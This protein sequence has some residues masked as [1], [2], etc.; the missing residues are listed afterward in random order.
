M[1]KAYW[2]VVALVVV[3]L[4]GVAALSFYPGDFAV[5]GIKLNRSTLAET[6]RGVMHPD[7]TAQSDTTVLAGPHQHPKG[8]RAPMDTTSKTI[9][10]IGDSMLEGLGPRLAAYADQNGHKLINVIW[11]SSS[12]E[13]WGS[14]GRLRTLIEEYKPNYIFVCLG[15]NELFVKDIRQKRQRYLDEMLAEIGNIPYVWIG[16]PNWKP[17][18]GIND[19]LQA[20]IADGCFYL[21]N[22]QHF[23]RA[24]DGAHPT[25]ASAAAWCDRVCQ[26]VMNTSTYPIMLNVP[27]VFKSRAKTIVYQPVQ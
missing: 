26:W 12:T 10:F 17:D 5:A 27:S 16:P 1:N 6:L 3:A 2:G 19:M 22:G 9:L 25:K 13:I 4:A 14:T 7:T 21:S 18:T 11:Y 8:W 24:R 15:A 23:D 20:S